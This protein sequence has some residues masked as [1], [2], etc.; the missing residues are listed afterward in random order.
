M[1]ISIIVRIVFYKLTKICFCYVSL[2]VPLIWLKSLETRSMVQRTTHHTSA[3]LFAPARGPHPIC[4]CQARAL[5]TLAQLNHVPSFFDFPS[6]GAFGRSVRSAVVAA[7]LLLLTCVWSATAADLPALG[8]VFRSLTLS[9][10]VAGAV[11][12]LVAT[13]DLPSIDLESLMPPEDNS[14]L[15]PLRIVFSLP[16]SFQLASA[17][18]AD[19]ETGEDN[20]SLSLNDILIPGSF[21]ALPVFDESAPALAASDNDAL[22]LIFS[23]P[24][25]G[26][27]ALNTALVAATAAEEQALLTVACSTVRV[28]AEINSQ[29]KATA[30][31]QALAATPAVGPVEPAE[32]SEPSDG[33]DE[34]NDNSAS[35]TTDSDG[36]TD[37]GAGDSGNDDDENSTLPSPLGV[38]YSTITQ[39]L[40]PLS[41]PVILPAPMTSGSGSG[42]GSDSS[43]STGSETPSPAETP[44]LADR[45]SVSYF[46]YLF[47]L[48]GVTVHLSNLKHAIQPGMVLTFTLPP[49]IPALPTAKC[50]AVTANVGY[51]ASVTTVINNR[52][53]TL[54]HG[55]AP[56]GADLDLL[57]TAVV[58]NPANDSVASFE[59]M[60]V[61]LLTPLGASI[62]A[63][64]VPAASSGVSAPP[65]GADALSNPILRT[66]AKS[67]QFTG[68]TVSQTGNYSFALEQLNGLT[69]A[70]QSVIEEVIPPAWG[71]GGSNPGDVVCTIDNKT[72]DAVVSIKNLT[73]GAVSSLETYAASV[74]TP[75]DGSGASEL[76]DIFAGG[77]ALPAGLAR[78][79]SITVPD[80]LTGLALESLS[81]MCDGF[82][83]PATL[84]DLS[85]GALGSVIRFP[86]G[87]SAA[88]LPPGASTGGALANV[89]TMGEDQ[90]D[91]FL[92][93]LLSGNG[94]QSNKLVKKMKM[95]IDP[96]GVEMSP[97]D[98]FSVILP[99]QVFAIPT[100]SRCTLTRLGGM[101]WALTPQSLF[102]NMRFDFTLGSLVQTASTAPTVSS[103]AASTVDSAVLECSE[104]ILL[105]PESAANQTLTADNIIAQVFRTVTTPLAG[106]LVSDDPAPAPGLEP[107][108]EAAT[109][110]VTPFAAPVSAAARTMSTLAAAS[111]S[112]S[113]VLVA[114]SVNVM[115]TSTTP[116]SAGLGDPTF[117]LSGGND[118]SAGYVGTLVISI[119][120]FP[121]ALES[122]D[123]VTIVLPP[124]TWKLTTYYEPGT[125]RCVFSSN[126]IAGIAG[127][128]N[129]L[130]DNN[131]SFQISK[132]V[133]ATD[134][135]IKAECT[136]A[137]FPQISITAGVNDGTPGVQVNRGGGNAVIYSR[138]FG[139]YSSVY[140]VNPAEL[141]ALYRKFT[142]DEYGQMSVLFNLPFAVKEDEAFYLSLESAWFTAGLSPNCSINYV[143]A[144]TTEFALEGD[145]AVVRATLASGIS[146]P[147]TTVN[148]LSCGNINPPRTAPARQVVFA[149][150]TSLSSG[151]TRAR[152]DK[153]DI[154]VMESSLATTLFESTFSQ[155]KTGDNT[156][157]TVA[158]QRFPVKL[159]QGSTILLQMPVD[160][161]R[162]D[163]TL[164]TVT[165]Y[166]GEGFVDRT[167]IFRTIEST[168]EIGTAGITITLTKPL[169]SALIIT[170]LTCTNIIPTVAYAVRTS[171]GL[172]VTPKNGEPLTRSGGR[173][174][175]I[176][177]SEMGLTNR[178]AAVSNTKAGGL[179]ELTLSVKPIRVALLQGDTVTVSL[180]TRF[181]FASTSRCSMTVS[182]DGTNYMN[183]GGDFGISIETQNS[184]SNNV[185]YRVSMKITE[186]R[187]RQLALIYRYDSYL[188]IQCTEVKNPGQETGGLSD[189]TV[190]TGT[191]DLKTKA[192]FT[193]AILTQIEPGVLGLT[194]RRI[195]HSAPWINQTGTLTVAINAITNAVPSSFEGGSV[196]WQMPLTWSFNAMMQATV[197]TVSGNYPSGSTSIITGYMYHTV[198]F[199]PNS[200]LTPGSYT[201][202]CTNVK[203]PS[204]AERERTDLSITTYKD[205]LR[206]DVQPSAILTEVYTTRPPDFI[207]ATVIHNLIF[208]KNTQL[209]SSERAVFKSIYDDI[210]TPIQ[211]SSELKS[212]TLYDIAG[213]RPPARIVEVTSG[214]NSANRRPNLGGDSGDAGLTVDSDLTLDDDTVEYLP[215]ET[216]EV[217]DFGAEVDSHSDDIGTESMTVDVDAQGPRRR[218]M[219]TLSRL[220]MRQ[221]GK[222][223]VVGTTVS[224]TSPDVK[225]EDIA[226][227]LVTQYSVF[228]QRVYSSLGYRLVDLVD[229]SG[230]NYPATCFDGVQAQDETDTDCGG[231][232]CPGCRHGKMCLRITDCESKLC[233]N[234]QCEGG[235]NAAAGPASASGPGALALVAAATLAAAVF[236]TWRGLCARRL[237]VKYD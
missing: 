146:V 72:A 75:A 219:G 226:L 45:V 40:A 84:F 211:C 138:E 199:K 17:S 68:T 166:P 233:V 215:A 51:I 194:T 19:A 142:F 112:P 117:V 105:V 154:P 21:T 81:V 115:L 61:S 16:S 177:A 83:S 204:A 206:I 133:P 93:P 134:G 168:T 161:L 158:I 197:C 89:V 155:L 34:D 224:T 88:T 171:L 200:A 116:P 86:N 26:V 193:A 62:A 210:V 79:L 132:A 118:R 106:A 67:V 229:D 64:H 222:Y 49:S 23:L 126:T 140:A 22:H 110:T 195:H 131:F 181:G 2:Q 188:S 202:T 127:S 189:I 60:E 124:N 191:T 98:V 178:V 221:T 136:N 99:T 218:S 213:F 8:D 217:I 6:S 100:A 5:I 107:N 157:M 113:R 179:G 135:L 167:T 192:T 47:F 1:Y 237:A 123:I 232:D 55:F 53:R 28:P 4:F 236:A 32:P 186:S 185:A 145:R 111:D 18:D 9:N 78:V 96:V 65:T 184:L 130:Y 71:L 102:N 80:A 58:G 174:P 73:S 46:T 180:D 104:V 183:Q 42:S 30:K 119:V 190:T 38:L 234:N 114:E 50:S 173:I 176:T 52:V 129:P 165:Q 94:V 85:R 87:T 228:T 150:M 196:Q 37:G 137:K 214:T 70:A 29:Y 57:C 227:H 101:A 223:L 77:A 25:A 230:G 147:E 207:R 151:R 95:V 141:G 3:A 182:N 153:L 109:I 125:S 108:D 10:D 187:E 24:A 175:P 144:R 139:Q 212:Q 48:K 76:S 121:I 41:L 162:S 12:S 39:T 225:M 163:D 59:G 156:T 122:M 14:A 149:L 31:L 56:V 152:T 7:V 74:G 148:I 220:S 160:L 66:I 54:L 216:D 203:V 63:S 231:P 164:C 44:Q 69:L 90:A 92:I 198:T 27:D 159:E 97:G 172:L 35:G 170:R 15:D 143:A 208:Q 209:S 235:T 201:I 120:N 20:C 169:T 82:V 103:T 11:S 205:T 128:L 91:I 33:E 43:T 13:F 36:S